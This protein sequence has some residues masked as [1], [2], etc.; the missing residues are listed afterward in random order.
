MGNIEISVKSSFFNIPT[1][2]IRE[3]LQVLVNSVVQHCFYTI[4]M[5]HDGNKGGIH[6]YSPTKYNIPQGQNPRK[7]FFFV[8]S[9]NCLYAERHIMVKNTLGS[10]RFSNHVKQKQRFLMLVSH[11][12]NKLNQLVF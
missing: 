1:V 9:I 4:C 10:N 6:I 2:P 3:V 5:L 11:F 7:Y 8:H 12:F